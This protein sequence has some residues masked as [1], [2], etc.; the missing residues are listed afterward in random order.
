MT[1]T[2]QLTKIR[3]HLKRGGVLTP[4]T[5]LNMFGTF[6]LSAHIYVLRHDEGLDIVTKKVSNRNGN[7]FAEYSLRN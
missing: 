2:S 3:T 5:A 6:R 1:K 4:V 7:V